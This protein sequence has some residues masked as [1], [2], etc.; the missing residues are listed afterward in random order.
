MC[1]QTPSL[2]ASRNHTLSDAAAAHLDKERLLGRSEATLKTYRGA[3]YRLVAWLAN[4]DVADAR[5][6]TSAHLEAYARTTLERVSRNSAHLYL[7]M[8]RTFFRDLAGA[9]RLLLD[10]A[11]QL[12]MPRLD[13]KHVGP[14]LTREEIDRV[15][16][17]PDIGTPLGI[18]DRALLEFLYSTGLRVSEAWRMKTADVDPGEGS[19]LV[20]AGKGAK[21]RV[22]PIGKAAVEWLV[23]YLAEVRPRLEAHRPGVEELFL[24]HH[25]R[26]FGDQMLAMHLKKLGRKAGVAMRLTCHVIRRTLATGLLRNGASPQEVAAILGHEDVR[27]LG[28]YVAFAAREVKEAHAKCHPREG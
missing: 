4:Q 24:T 2:T 15:L 25:G 22:V 20:R 27:S 5:E 6:V 18:R 12:A 7:R 11:A 9:H 16:A 28:R 3:L 10:P 13:R 19:A 23:R 26:A 1:A 17:G 21:D 8:V 14:I